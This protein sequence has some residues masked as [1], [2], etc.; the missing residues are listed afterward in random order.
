M[1]I[2][3]KY[4]V[5]LGVVC[6]ALLL[7][8]A[9][10][11][12]ATAS[13][14]PIPLP[15]HP[16]PDFQRAE[17]LNLNGPWQFQTDKA[18]AG[19]SEKW[20]AGQIAF[21]ETIRVPFPWG[22]P[23][24]G[25]KD[26]API[27]W[28]ARTVR[29]PESWRGQRVFLVIGACDWETRAWLDGQPLGTHQGGYTPFEFEITSLL[30]AGQDQRLVLRIDD[31][32]RP[33]KLEGK[34]GY[35][36]ARG[37]WQTVYLEARPSLHLDLIHFEPDLDAARVTVRARFSGPASGGA[38]LALRFRTGDVPET[39]VPVAEG[40]TE[41]RFRMAIPRPRAWSLEDPFLYEVEAA[42]RAGSVEDRVSTYFGMRKIS[43][44]NLPG[45]TH[46]YV[47]LNGRPVYLQMTLDQSYHPEGFYT[48]PSDAF[49]RDEILRSRR[50]GLNANRLHVK[51]DVPRK[52]YWADRL[53]LLIMADV[54]N[55]WG[56]P[57]ADMR[58]EID[59]A[60]RGMIDRDFNHPSIFSWVPFNE[61]W[62]L[63][64]GKN[65][66]RRYLPETQEWVASVYRLAR[67]LDP[68]R[69]VEDNSPCN[70]DHVETDLNSWH[71]YLP[72]YEW[73]GHLDQ[74]CRDTFPGSRWNF[75]GGRAQANQPLLNSECGNVWGY[76]GSTG[77]V[78]WS[79]D[80]H[81]MMN[82]FRRHPKVCGWLYTEHHDVINE[83]NGYYRYDRTDKITG[84]DSIV[85]G[86]TLGDLH[87]PFYLAPEGPLCREVKPGQKVRLPIWA[88]FMTDRA[89]SSALKLRA[90]LTGVNTLGATEQ[91]GEQVHAVP[92]Q[93]WMSKALAP[94]EVTMPDHAVLAVLKIVLEDETGA[95]LHRNF[96]AFLVGDGAAP[97]DETAGSLR[98]LRFA[99]SAFSSA[100]WSSKQWDV[101]GGLKVNGAGHGHFEYRLPW[102]AGLEP[103]Q[104]DAAS[105]R[106]EASA[107]ILFGKDR[108][109]AGELEGDYMR[110]K[111]TLD[112][113]RNPNAYPMTDT[114]P[115]PSA[116]RVRVSGLA[117]GLYDLP[118]D[119]ADH[120][121]ILSWAAQPQDRKLREAGSYG[122]LIQAPIPKE[123]IARAARSGEIV[124]RFE[125]DASQPG[126]LAL[127]GE[128]FGRYPM[129]P[130]L[131]FSM[132]SSRR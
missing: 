9:C 5:Q 122:Y 53:G 18:D 104:I 58:R 123:A 19:L 101:L 14:E 81:L 117:S 85:E 28:Y 4:L 47:S 54:P 62:G 67:Q 94:L 126:G 39:V 32:A 110:G 105:L 8:M 118:D 128:R 59:V 29:A 42:L 99:P 22:S 108:T 115:S 69:L 34:Q 61:T 102:P 23:L 41:H 84:L 120:R 77:D 76:E 100:R 68:T 27:A 35:G 80:Y 131:V 50:L 17:W 83:W 11:S 111:G 109:D 87:A 65:P 63:F 7:G 74:V 16:R 95:A 125:V 2:A 56:E 127:Y 88:S 13:D 93:P 38:A 103:G 20:S 79:W 75:I 33:F 89:P 116:V 66:N 49:M 15:E 73:G 52:L 90:A 71:A 130:T 129:D 82:E 106:F 45:T 10:G 72:G 31:A 36:N 57:D 24:S 43:V 114:V 78:D 51:I 91:F 21:R 12:I 113:S 55:S 26:D 64:T 70:H 30:K 119:P 25:V 97:R 37:I 121:G 6:Q 3:S 40:K 92:F 44:M 124:I 107:K 132:R 86:M 112:P 1:R 48:F 98:I 60:L 46:P 96:T